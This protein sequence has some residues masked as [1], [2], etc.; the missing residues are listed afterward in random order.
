LTLKQ[1]SSGRVYAATLPRV[2]AV[3]TQNDDDDASDVSWSM[4]RAT[5]ASNTSRSLASAGSGS[6][7]S[8]NQRSS[9]SSRRAASAEPHNPTPPAATT[10]VRSQ[11]TDTVVRSQLHREAWDFGAAFREKEPV[12]ALEG[13]RKD[14]GLS[15][16]KMLFG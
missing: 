14:K 10:V 8:S 7:A 13:Q 3:F 9:A 12:V 5:L 4:N 16:T 11:V 1:A 2:R 15:L 6:H